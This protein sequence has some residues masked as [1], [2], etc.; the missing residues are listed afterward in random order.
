MKTSL[1]EKL[2]KARIQAG[3]EKVSDAIRALEEA[4]RPISAPYLYN[5]ES[6]RQ[7]ISSFYTLANLAEFYNVSLDYLAGLSDDPIPRQK[8]F[9]PQWW[10]FV[11]LLTQLSPRRWTDLFAIAEVF[12]EI[13]EEQI[14]DPLLARYDALMRVAEKRGLLQELESEMEDALQEYNQ[15]DQQQQQRRAG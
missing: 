9:P 14:E 13:E 1:G 15:E 5:I 8:D 12:L 3:Y 4:G 7:S 6:D 2:Q 11:N 10:E